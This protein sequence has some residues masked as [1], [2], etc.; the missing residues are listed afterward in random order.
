MLQK[1]TRKPRHL[2]LARYNYTWHAR[3]NYY[4]I[5]CI[6]LKLP[7]KKVI[8]IKKQVDFHI[9]MYKKKYKL[10]I[11]QSNT[12]E[13]IL[14]RQSNVQRRRECNMPRK[15]LVNTARTGRNKIQDLQPQGNKLSNAKQ[16]HFLAASSRNDLE[17]TII[18]F[19]TMI[20]AMTSWTCK[21]KVRH[22]TNKWCKEKTKHRN[23]I[24]TCQAKN[25]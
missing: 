8:N 15:P 9:G 24:E 22:I 16:N 1:K 21:C 17:V 23:S 10:V 3:R 4:Y 11:L 20:P 13:W 12:D 2:V 6:A 14:C 18:S 7:D 19:C 5:I 25:F